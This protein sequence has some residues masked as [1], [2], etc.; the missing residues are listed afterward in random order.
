MRSD[1]Y[2]VL[3]VSRDADEAE[4][5]K[6]F[7][8]VAREL[9]PDVNR[10]DPEAEEKFK[11]A[12]EAYEIL[13]DAERRSTYDRFGFEGLD[14]RGYASQA[15][16][17]GS[18]AD[19]FDAFFGGDPFGA[20][21]GRGGGGRIQGGDIAV[22]VEI[23]LAEAATG[24]Q[25][26]VA[27]ELVDTCE[28][29]RGNGAEPGTPIRTCDRCDGAGQIRQVTR[30][31]FGQMVRAAPCDR[32][33]GEGR[34]AESPCGECDGRGRVVATRTWEVAVPA[35]IESGQRIRIAGAGHAG[36][37]GGGQGNLYVEVRVAPDE[38][39]ERDRDDLVSLVEVPATR[40]MLG[41]AVT[42]ATLD[43]DREVNVPPGTRTGDVATLGGLGLPGLRSSRRGDQ[44]VVFNV[45]VPTNLTDEQR[46]LAEQLDA[47]I[48][49]DNLRRDEAGEG[50]FSRVRRAF[51]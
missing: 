6:T 24:T 41:T 1:P 40:A 18:F 31:A 44:R 21:F 8:R 51:G 29:C 33:R 46:E 47:T 49:E 30:T 22:E 10:H 36:E 42:V 13:S 45:I 11:E 23:S 27:Y 14:S 48:T 17:F 43:G 2:E 25:A 35:G 16:G 15:H 50:F 7:R 12:A 5:K 28:H 38:R 32:C 4:I 37:S 34:V 20:A 39:F 26:D 3:G 19:I 9:H